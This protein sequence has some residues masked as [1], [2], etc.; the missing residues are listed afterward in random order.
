MI[1]FGDGVVK[2][3][4][5]VQLLGWALIEPGFLEAG[6]VWLTLTPPPWASPQEDDDEV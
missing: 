6:G 3:L 4:S 5:S 1:V 2:G